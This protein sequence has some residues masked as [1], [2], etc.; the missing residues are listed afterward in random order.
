MRP[1][2]KPWS[3]FVIPMEKTGLLEDFT[4]VPKTGTMGGL[5]PVEEIPGIERYFCQI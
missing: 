2:P 1:S 3:P 5:V 4:V